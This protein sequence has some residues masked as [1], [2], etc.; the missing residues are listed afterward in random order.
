MTWFNILFFGVFVIFF[1]KLLTL[2]LAIDLDVDIDFDG[3]TD[4]DVSGMLSFKGV[5]HFLMGFSS[6]LTAVGY[7]NTHSLA[8][9]Y[10]FSLSTYIFAVCV[11]IVTMVLLFY[12]YKFML[13]LNHYTSNNLNLNN[14]HGKVYLIESD[15]QYQVLVDTPNGT[16]RKTAYSEN[17]THK[18]GE[19]IVLTWDKDNKRYIF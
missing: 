14:M 2:W 18:I 4:I 7:G 11:G 6:V 5:L 19:D 15:G 17:K 13:K 10:T 9:P 12:L 8:I 16:F 3:D 1:L